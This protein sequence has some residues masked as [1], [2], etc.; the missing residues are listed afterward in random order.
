MA[1]AIKCD[2]KPFT[3]GAQEEEEHERDLDAENL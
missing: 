2:V 3:A 1:F